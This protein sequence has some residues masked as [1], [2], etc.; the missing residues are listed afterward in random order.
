MNSCRFWVVQRRP[1]VSDQGQRCVVERS[2]EPRIAAMYRI[3]AAGSRLLG[4]E[5]GHFRSFPPFRRSCRQ[6]PDSKYSRHMLGTVR[7]RSFFKAVAHS[8]ATLVGDERGSYVRSSNS[9]TVTATLSCPS[10]RSISR[11]TGWLIC[12][13]RSVRPKWNCCL[14]GWSRCLAASEPPTP[15][16]ASTPLA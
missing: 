8:F 12:E 11:A 10:A 5:D 9:R 1:V 2:F 14:A 15:L 13:N 16:A 3:A 6:R 7:T 4:V